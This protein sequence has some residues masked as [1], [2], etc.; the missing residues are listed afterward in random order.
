M[1]EN[2][3]V[4]I[5][6]DWVE[7]M[8]VLTDDLEKLELTPGTPSYN[9]QQGM[10]AAA[11]RYRLSKDQ[12]SENTILNFIPPNSFDLIFKSGSGE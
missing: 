1:P 4:K 7:E 10:V 11:R 12:D 9:F 6:R 8:C 2:E 5:L 3:K